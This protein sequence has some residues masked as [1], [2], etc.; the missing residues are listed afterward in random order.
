M[1]RP[2][3]LSLL[4]LCACGET[5]EKTVAADDGSS[6]TASTG[7]T[8]DG[9]DDGGA[10]GTDDSGDDGTGGADGE[11]AD[12][13]SGGGGADGDM[14]TADAYSA[15][16]CSLVDSETT[17]LVLGASEAEANTALV[18]PAEGAAWRLQMPPSGDG[19]FTVE[20]PDWMTV[21]RFFTEDGVE[22]E[23]FGGEP[24]S[25][26]LRNGSCPD[27]GISDQRWAFHD[28]GAYTVRVAEGAPAEVWFTVV[29]EE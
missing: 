10:G 6:T 9:S 29:K 26:V 27:A 18:L 19:W 3:L 23:I 25:G 7:T 12:G 13:G 11:G 24:F 2:V 4:A 17:L 20:V 5:S 1:N 15:A 22:L 8:E 21:V 28:W 16:G 14:S